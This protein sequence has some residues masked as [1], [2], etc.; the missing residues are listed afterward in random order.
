MNLDKLQNWLQENGMDVAYVSSPTTINYF[1]GFIT[2]P[3]KESLSF[4]PSRTLNPSSSA[5][6]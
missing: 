1:T 6:P 5:R 2:D 4:S 3:E